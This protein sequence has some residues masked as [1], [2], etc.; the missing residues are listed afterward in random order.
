MVNQPVFGF[1]FGKQFR[2][3]THRNLTF[4][5][6]SP[7]VVCKGANKD[8]ICVTP[9]VTRSEGRSPWTRNGSFCRILFP[10]RPRQGLFYVP[11]LQRSTWFEALAS[12]IVTSPGTAAFIV[13]II[14]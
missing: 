12:R 10:H 13:L 11:T 2:K 14:M 9:G 6:M 4:R 8:K 3:I 5:T 7:C 1:Q